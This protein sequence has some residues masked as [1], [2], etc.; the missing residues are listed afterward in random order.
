MTSPRLQQ[1]FIRLW[2]SCQGEPQ[3]TTLQ[4][5][6]LRLHCSRRHI[7][8]L[9]NAMQQA[10]WLEWQAQPGRGRRSWLRFNY[11]GLA[12]QQ[13]RAEQLLE[14]GYIDQLEQLVGDKQALRHMLLSHL[15][16]SF[17]QGRPVL[18]VLYYRSLINLLPGQPLRRSESHIVRQIFSGLT[19]IN[20]EKGE[21]EPDLAHHWQAISDCHWRFYLRPAVRFHHGR[22]LNADDVL[23]SLQRLQANPLFNH[24]TRISSPAALIVDIHLNQPD[25]WLPWLFGDSA[26]MILPSEWQQ[27]PDFACRPVGT[28]PYAVVR[29]QPSHLSI[30]AFDDYFGFRAL[31]DEV[32]I[33]VLPELNEALSYSGVQLQGSQESDD[34]MA[35]RQEEGCYFLLFD[36]RSQQ[37]QDQDH[38]RWLSDVFNP[39]MMLSQASPAGQSFW[40]PAFGLL[41]R[42]HHRRIT[43]PGPKPPGLEQVTVTLFAAH[44]EFDDLSR[45]LRQALAPTGVTL[46]INQMDYDS[47]YHGRAQ[48]D[49]WL[50]S[51]N[52]FLPLEYSLFATLYEMPLMHLCLQRDATP[53]LEAWRQN[54][55]P[56]AEW[57]HDLVAEHHLHPLFHHWLLLHG[58]RSL[59]GVRLNTLGWFDFKSAWFA[60]PDA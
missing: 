10:G 46:V 22:E 12:L 4:Q 28:G 44:S 24:I 59:R 13:Q 20:E 6:A 8:S 47:W 29:N 32:H 5:L 45:L 53:R 58:Q 15:G 17:R 51:A 19:R 3:H 56:L 48:S 23:Q 25:H 43:T 26:A 9:L 35:T 31:I 37:M 57:C 27:M 40:S 39:V 42:W 16:K 60:P 7:R 30:H 38:R 55:L 2:Q 52:F 54:R 11:T 21:P 36:Q 14:Q 34:M 18:R 49:I 1:Q 50:G 41:P 33:W